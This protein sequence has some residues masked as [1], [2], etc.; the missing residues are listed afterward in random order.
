MS[1]GEFEEKFGELTDPEDVRS[2]LGAARDL[3]QDFEPGK[4]PVLWRILLAQYLIYKAILILASEGS[5]SAGWF[6]DPGGSLTASEAESVRWRRE[7][8]RADQ[9]KDAAVSAVELGVTRY[10]KELVLPE[11]EH[12]LRDA[13]APRPQPEFPA[14]LAH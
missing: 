14:H 7:N 6:A 2:P 4:R 5:I 13:A 12:L 1:F 9:D 11:V 10:I 8:S 3:F